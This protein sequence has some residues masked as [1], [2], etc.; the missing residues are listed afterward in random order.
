MEA[1][2][3]A[4]NAEKI[5]KPLFVIQGA[6]DARVNI[7]ESDQMVE[8]LRAR[9]FEVPYMVKYDEGHGFGHEHNRLEMY[10]CMMGFFARHLNQDF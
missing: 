2:S 10:K 8:N 3:P 7:N 9:G 4:L 6:N 1:V 5:N